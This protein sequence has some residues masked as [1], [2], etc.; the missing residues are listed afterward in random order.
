MEKIEGIRILQVDGLN[1]GL[2]AWA[3][4]AAPPTR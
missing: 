3:R 4:A 1:G 2:A